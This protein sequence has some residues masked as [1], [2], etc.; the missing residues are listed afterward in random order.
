MI[1]KNKNLDIPHGNTVI[2]RYI[3]LDRFLDLPMS[4]ELF[5]SNAAKMFDKYEGFIPKRNQSY[6][7]F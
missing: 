7:Q 5:F 1:V 4:Q 2:W 6:L 3:G